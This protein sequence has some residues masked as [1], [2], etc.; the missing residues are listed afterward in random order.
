M[1]ERRDTLNHS[2]AMRVLAVLAAVFAASG[3]LSAQE[4]PAQ[5][6]T[7]IL[8]TSGFWRFYLTLRTPVVRDGDALKEIGGACNTPAPP[9]D[10]TVSDF[11][12]S[13]W[14]RIA[15]APFATWSHWEECARANVGFLYCSRSS[16]AVAEVC[17]R[18]KFQIDDPAGAKA[19][20]LTLKYRGGVAVSV[21]G[22]E[23]AREN[24]PRQGPLT[25]VTPAEIYPHDV[26][27][28]PDGDLPRGYGG[29]GSKS[30]R[31]P[32]RIRSAEIEIPAAALRKGTNVLA[33]DFHRSPLPKDV[34]DKLKPLKDYDVT[35]CAWEACG[36]FSAR[37]ESPSADATRTNAV[38]P[39]GLE[40]WNSN[41]LRTDTDVDWG[42]PNEPLKPIRIVGAQNGVFSGK[43]VVGS[44][45]DIQGLKASVGDLLG[46][47]GAKIP[48]S[49]VTIRFAAPD[50]PRAESDFNRFDSLLE[51]PPAE[52]PVR[53]KKADPNS[54]RV[55][56]GQPVAVPGAVVPVWLTV[57]VPADA[58]PGDYRATLSIVAGGR[59]LA[60][61]VE[62][63]VAGFALPDAKDRRTFVELVESPDT[64]AIE[65]GDPLWSEAHWKRV[66]RSLTFCGQAGSK[67]AYVPL[68]AETNLGNEQSMVRWVKEG[69]GK[70]RYDFSVMD[71]YLDLVAKRQG[72]PAVV[73]FVL[74]DN[75]LEGGEFGDQVERLEGKSVREE[76]LGWKGKGPE[77]TM[78]EGGKA[79]KLQLPQYSDPG[80][81]E[82]WEPLAKALRERMKKRGWEAACAI[83]LATDARPAPAVMDLW[84]QILPGIPWASMAHPLR[85]DIQKVPVLYTGGVWAPRFIS[86]DGTS[87]EGWKN[88]RFVAQFARD[89]TE[90]NPLTVFR[91]IGEM[92]VG[93]DQRGFCRWGADCW[94]V[95]KDRKGVRT[96]RAYERYAK[97]NWR[98]LN[99]KTA[100]LG[101]GP[102]GPV[103]TVRFEAMREGIEECEARIFIEQALDGGKLP[104]AL[105]AR[106]KETI[107]ERNRNLVM[108]LGNHT[109]E[110]FQ[111]IG[112]YWR[113]HD[114]HCDSGL[115]GYY[116]YQTSGWQD[117]TQKLYDLAAD[118]LASSRGSK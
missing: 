57:D 45:G 81:K 28:L 108:G 51:S 2:R 59:D 93:G 111:D 113:V 48:A 47:S 17:L 66:E 104:P 13:G 34:Y 31:L 29:K 1:G 10:W 56:P 97:A 62:L 63:H 72:P 64:L 99:V 67:V 105:A 77:V 36:L 19:L 25:P 4:K 87:R 15:G 114:W 79:S 71:R 37:L 115:V 9:A 89:V 24:L 118:V 92:N 103:A 83:G 69:E 41:L 38:R 14:V 90:Y 40:V 82:L 112:A 46:A 39:A 27:F 116:W 55:L 61:P 74:W 94:P 23:I 16:L 53:R 73:C 43:V 80:A 22:R 52:I 58:K 6:G 78:L 30:D 12:D 26:Y 84:K 20:K 60:V 91:C 96:G 35:F 5:A 100:F 21:N 70:Y 18:G 85:T 101:A 44:T 102:D 65:Y 68:I 75:Y 42:D 109:L 110:G 106:V 8:D 3:P 49:S 107:A 76:R 33:L 7:V 50:L 11:D 32:L 88:P 54:V 86:Y 117:R 95:L 98:N